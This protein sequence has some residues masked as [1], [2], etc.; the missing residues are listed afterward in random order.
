VWVRFVEGVQY[1]RK[2]AMIAVILLQVSILIAVEKSFASL[3]PSFALDFLGYQVRDIT[4]LFIVPTAV[5]TLLGVGLANKLKS[6]VPKHRLITF[7]ISLDALALLLA[8]IIVP[9]TRFLPELIP[10]FTPEGVR[11]FLVVLLAATSGFADPFILVSAQT[12]FQERTP[13]AEQGRVFGLQNTVQNLFA[14]VPVIAIGALSGVVAVP[15]V[16]SA[17]GGIV[18][19]TA[20]VGAVFYHRRQQHT[21]VKA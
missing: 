21:A 5:G 10:G 4:L 13:N 3:M 11:L 18:C 8:V 16:I 15:V 6:R 2:D 20:V 1:V 19:I 9:L 17:L 12:I 14:F 7:G